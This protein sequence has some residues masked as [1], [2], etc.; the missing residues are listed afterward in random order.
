[1]AELAGE[2]LERIED[3]LE[4]MGVELVEAR[5]LGPKARRMLRLTIYHPEGVDLRLCEEVSEVVGSLLDELD[6]IEG[7]YTLEV[8]SPGLQRPLRGKRDFERA[9]GESVRLNLSDGT[10]VDGV[11]AVADE[12]GVRVSSSGREVEVGY[13]R[14][15]SA[16]TVFEW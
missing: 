2:V 16:R 13:D 11:L 5:L 15:R 6:P 4:A 7:S 3:L 1:M 9:V 14:I 8:S 12:E 10:V